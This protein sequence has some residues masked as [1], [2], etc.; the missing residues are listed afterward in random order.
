MPPNTCS[1]I[2][3]ARVATREQDLANVKSGDFVVT[4]FEISDVKVRVYGKVG[5]MTGLNRSQA[6][7]KGKTPAAITDSRMC[8]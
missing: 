8:S 2:L 5:V 3:S 4:A 1:P 6:S 7:F